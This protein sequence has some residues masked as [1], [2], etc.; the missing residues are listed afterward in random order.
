MITIDRE[1][2][3]GLSAFRQLVAGAR[4]TFQAGGY[5]IY[6]REGYDHL[7]YRGLALRH[8]N[9][10]TGKYETFTYEA[11]PEL[12]AW[13][14]THTC[15]SLDQALAGRDIKKEIRNLRRRARYS[16]TARYALAVP[17]IDSVKEQLKTAPGI[18]TNEDGEF[19]SRSLTDWYVAEFCTINHLRRAA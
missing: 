19:S 12:K 17:S 1:Y 3:A 2:P 9:G 11:S 7:Y 18:T 14:A 15:K 16:E 13:A 6:A 5:S 4:P 8:S 10:E